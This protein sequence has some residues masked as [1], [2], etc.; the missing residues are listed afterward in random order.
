MDN[1]FF[2]RTVLKQLFKKEASE[3]SVEKLPISES[4]WLE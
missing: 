3:K 4:I 1:C 2:T